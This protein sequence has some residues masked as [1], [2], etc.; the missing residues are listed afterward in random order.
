MQGH[1]F[2]EYFLTEGIQTTPEWRGSLAAPLEFASFQNAVQ[3][4]FEALD[5]SAE[6]NEAVTEQE[7]IRPVLELLDWVDYLPQQGS[8]R[9]EDIP[10]HLLL[11]DADSKFLAT[12]EARPQERYRYALVVEESKRFGLPLDSRDRHDKVKRGT[13]HGQILRYLST[14]DIVSDGN[15]RW[16]ILTN[17]GTWR[18][19]DYRSRPRS[20]AYFEVNLAE[21][22]KSDDSDSLRLFYLLFRRDSFTK[23]RGAT[24]SFLEAALDEGKRYEERVAQDLSSVVFDRAFPQLLDA[25]AA[26][27]EDRDL[28]RVR[29]AALIFLYRLLFVLYAEDRGLLPVNDPRYEDYGLRKP[30]R[31]HIASR[32]ERRAVFSTNACNYF[33]HLTTLCKLIDIGDHS[34]GLPPYNG[35]LFA[36]SAAP[37]LEEVQ[38]SD[39]VVASIIYDLSHTELGGARRFVNY[40][41]MS[42]QQL[43][44]IY[45]RLLERE[46]TWDGERKIEIR[47]NRYARK[48]SGSFFTPQGLVDLIVDRTLKPLVEERLRAFEKKAASL[49]GDRRTL[50]GSK[51]R[52]A[53]SRSGGGGP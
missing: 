19:Y 16:G 29:Q 14:A 15:V 33:N 17:G 39:H 26:S 40:R 13:P 21:L 44:S 10:D 11:P 27:T 30:V 42:V 38:L 41:D 49:K 18:L 53:E 48:D 43:G 31:E 32:M 25:L 7:L 8:G 46:P 2:T 50:V 51:G 34:I 52:V 23:Q 35:G 9:N 3:R 22:L 47:P 45:E 4:Q 1:L 24:T 28:A 37:L 6:W 5:H 12:G 20:T 36:T